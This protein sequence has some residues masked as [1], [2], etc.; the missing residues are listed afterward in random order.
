[1]SKIFKLFVFSFLILFLGGCG[2]T[3]KISD[4]GKINVVVSILPQKQFVEKIGGKK[5]NVTVLIPPGFSPA[6]Y[7][8]TPEQIKAVSQ[9]DVYFRIGIIGFEQTQLDK[10][11]SVNPEMKVIDTSENMSYRQLEAHSHEEKEPEDHDDEEGSD[12]HVWLSPKLV[13]SQAEVIRDTLADLYPQDKK[14]FEAGF[15]AFQS[16]L[17]QLDSD[18]AIAFAPIKGKTMLVFHPAFG[19]LAD[20]YGFH[21][22]HFEIEG[23]EPT[24]SQINNIANM[25]KRE[26]VKVIFVQKQFSQSSAQAL[27]QEIDG[28]VVQIDPLDPD[29]ISNMRHIATTITTELK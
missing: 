23:K 24:I 5:V 14:S 25:A 10:L 18:L 4:N 15:L 7:E 29:Y 11:T 12:P 21:Q 20:E 2:L 26:G 3:K 6:T 17:Q 19:Y 13:I 27:A 9:A 1:M 16:E 28:S 8:P 22:E